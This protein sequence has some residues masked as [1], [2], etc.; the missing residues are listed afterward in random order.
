MR[1]AAGRWVV[2]GLLAACSHP[3]ASSHFI[4]P[5]PLAAPGPIDPAVLGAAYIEQVGAIVQRDWAVFLEDLRLRLAPDHELNDGRLVALLDLRVAADG[6]IAELV[7]T[8][9][10]AYDFDRAAEELMRDAAPLPP[11]PPELRSDDGMLHLRWQFARDRRQAG[12]ATAA[13][14]RAL[15]PVG[16]AVP[17]LL[18]R[19]DLAEAARRVAAADPRDSGGAAQRLFIAA[20]AEALASPEAAVRRAAIDTI[21]AAHVAALGGRLL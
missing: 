13:I 19:G 6:R 15:W 14:T 7:V 2:F 12:P 3:A 21:G 1:F 11:P 18:D 16:R 9:S 5:P 17:M 4:V 8:G 10:G 20:L